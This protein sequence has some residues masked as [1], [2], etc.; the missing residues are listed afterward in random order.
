MRSWPIPAWRRCS[1]D[2]SSGGR[3]VHTGGTAGISRSHSEPASVTSPT[4]RSTAALEIPEFR[5]T[6]SPVEVVVTRSARETM[7]DDLFWSTRQDAF[8]SG[9]FCSQ[10]PHVMTG[11][12]RFVAT[13]TGDAQRSSG[14]LDNAMWRSAEPAFAIDGLDQLLAGIWHSHP[15]T[16]DGEPSDHDLSAWLARA[17]LERGAR[18]LQRLRGWAIYSS[19]P[20]GGSWRH[21]GTAAPTRLC[22]RCAAQQASRL[23]AS[24]C[25]RVALTTTT[26]SISNPWRKSL[27]ARSL[28]CLATH[29]WMG[30]YV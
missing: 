19:P 16:R 23:R 18:P 9:G 26:R 11:A 22:C 27:R 29:T 6:R 20:A 24:R 4:V 8:E 1:P 5:S 3:L 7:L 14:L 2:P 28:G 21:L 12:S 17:E 13:R 15:Q 25:Q 10:S 30:R